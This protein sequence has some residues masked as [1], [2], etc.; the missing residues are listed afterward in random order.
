MGNQPTT[1]KLYLKG[2]R[3]LPY[4]AAFKYHM[5]CKDISPVYNIQAL[6]LTVTF[7]EINACT[8]GYRC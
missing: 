8:I 5:N 2:V 3:F 7:F 6:S 4:F 1:L